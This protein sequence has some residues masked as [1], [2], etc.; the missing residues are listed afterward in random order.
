MFQVALC[1][2][3]NEQSRNASIASYRSRR[4]DLREGDS[5]AKVAQK[6]HCLQPYYTQQKWS[7]RIE[8]TLLL[9]KGLA[10]HTVP[11]IKGIRSYTSAL[12]YT[13]TLPISPTWAARCSPP[14]TPLQSRSRRSRRGPS[15]ARLRASMRWSR[16]CGS[17]WVGPSLI[18]WPQL[19]GEP[20]SASRD[21]PCPERD[22]AQG[23]TNDRRKVGC[24]RAPWRH[25]PLSS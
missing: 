15:R 4:K 10:Y 12:R 25:V 19:A 23:E 2:M 3:C 8:F 21:R 17:G 11:F 9:P 1:S 7:P 22:T 14:W 16:G 24:V 5:K 18:G 13:H 20:T 6:D